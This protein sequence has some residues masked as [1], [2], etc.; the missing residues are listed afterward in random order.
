MTIQ[1]YLPP[2]Y[3]LTADT[4]SYSFSRHIVPTEL[5]PDIVWWDSNGLVLYIIEL[6]I[7]FKT[8][9]KCIKYDSII[10]RA[11]DSGYSATFLPLEVGSREIIILQ[12]FA[13][14]KEKVGIPQHPFSAML[15][16]VVVAKCYQVLSS[17]LVHKKDTSCLFFS[18]CI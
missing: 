8:D 10:Q 6:I 14:L 5:H 17:D 1:E 13:T 16:R 7:A 11:R 2:P 12:S 3:E 18:S 9:R 15:L 4:V